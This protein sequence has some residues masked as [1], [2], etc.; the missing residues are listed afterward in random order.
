MTSKVCVQCCQRR[1][2]LLLGWLLLKQTHRC[3]GLVGEADVKVQPGL[4]WSGGGEEDL[5]KD[6][7]K[8]TD[9]P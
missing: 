5:Q 9:R 6:L 1:L 7:V 2:F 8:R 3:T 4:P